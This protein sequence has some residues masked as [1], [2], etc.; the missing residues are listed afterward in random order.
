[1]KH[2]NTIT[3]LMCR[4]AKTKGLKPFPYKKVGFVFLD[5]ESILPSPLQMI[6]EEGLHGEIS[7]LAELVD[8]F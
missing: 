5:M 8:F 1:M 6:F 2:F 7:K 3:E 4:Q